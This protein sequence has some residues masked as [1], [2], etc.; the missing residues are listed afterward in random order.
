MFLFKPRPT[1]YASLTLLAMALVACNGG[2]DDH[3][4]VTNTS[5][6]P[7]PPANRNVVDSAPVPDVPAFVDNIATNQRG[8]ARFA[9]LDTNAGV[10]LASRFLDLWHP[11]TE[12][13]DAGVTAPAV[14][15][16]P[17]ITPSTWTGLSM[18]M[19][20]RR[21]TSIHRSPSRG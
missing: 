19:E 14:G 2:G 10:R 11:L 9:T 13:V 20:L 1:I 21:F 12:I 15:S 6:P 4:V 16:F 3:S 5:V 7:A 18:R 17:A 8:D